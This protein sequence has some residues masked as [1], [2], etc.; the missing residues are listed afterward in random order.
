VGHFARWPI[1]PFQVAILSLTRVSCN[2]RHRLS[3]T[4]S[5]D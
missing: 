2:T 3:L 1:A 4:V 5:K